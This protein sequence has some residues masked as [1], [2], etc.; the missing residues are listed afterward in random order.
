MKFTDIFFLMHCL[1]EKKAVLLFTFYAVS[2]EREKKPLWKVFFVISIRGR[3]FKWVEIKLFPS[4]P[5]L[6]A[7][8]AFPGDLFHL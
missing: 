3:G 4:C 1:P 6:P 8:A 7:A 2:K 5:K